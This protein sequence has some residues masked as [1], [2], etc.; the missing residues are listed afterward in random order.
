MTP[1]DDGSVTWL[2]G[3]LKAG[4][5][6]AAQQLLQRYF[7]RLVHLARSRLRSARRAGAIEDEEEAALSAFDSFCRGATTDRFPQLVDRDDLWRL[8]VVLTVRKVCGQL[9]RQSADKRGGDRLLGET[10]LINASL[11]RLA[12]HEPSPEMAALLVDEGPKD[13]QCNLSPPEP[14]GLA[15][16]R[17]ASPWPSARPRCEYAASCLIYAGI[18]SAR[19][20]W[21]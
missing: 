4:D 13:R 20:G 21:R 19:M 1:E 10:A 12:A 5:E 8:L 14:R 7:H 9:E 18:I 6:S 15:F 2:I 17:C 11:D 3:N 16:R